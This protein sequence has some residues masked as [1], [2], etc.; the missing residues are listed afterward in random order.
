M[1]RPLN[2]GVVRVASA[3]PAQ[4]SRCFAAAGLR[5]IS[6]AGTPRPELAPCQGGASL[7]SLFDGYGGGCAGDRC[8]SW[9]EGVR[10]ASPR[11]GGLCPPSRSAREAPAE[12]AAKPRRAPTRSG[13]PRLGTP[14]PRT[15]AWPPTPPAPTRREFGVRCACRRNQAQARIRD[16]TQAPRGHTR[17]KAESAAVE[18][19]S[20]S[21]EGAPCSERPTTKTA[22]RRELRLKD[23]LVRQPDR[24]E[25]SAVD[26]P[27]IDA[28]RE[29]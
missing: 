10:V 2:G 29:R 16:A 18:R 25:R 19:P 26:R 3:L 21:P 8:A 17:R 1:A 4:R 28:D 13:R 24:R 5:L 6:A 7:R 9:H 11:V 15:Q 12:G 20:H 14:L 23:R 22:R 27:R